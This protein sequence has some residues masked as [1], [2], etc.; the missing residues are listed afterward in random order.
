MISY[1][2]LL[3]CLLYMNPNIGLRYDM[4]TQSCLGFKSG[5][6]LQT[7]NRVCNI[8][9][10][11]DDEINVIKSFFNEIP[12]T[13]AVD[14]H[15]DATRTVLEKN[16]LKYKGSFP[17]MLLDLAIIKDHNDE[18]NFE[19]QH[20]NLH[21][22]TELKLWA[23]VFVRLFQINESELLKLL[24]C[25]IERIP[26]ALKLYLGY[27]QGAVASAC[28]VI[29]HQEIAAM[30]WVGTLPEYRNRGLA[31]ALSHKALNDAKDG[32]CKYAVLMSTAIAKK[33]YG[34]LGFEEYATYA[35]Y[36]SL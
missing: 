33:I 11:T 10:P 6:A 5:C 25:F 18:N 21:E 13:W 24:E 27:Y 31:F 28:M 30:H 26:N 16:N 36:G 22:T 17:A 34:H 29:I 23:S 4:I 15:D 12:F 9:V 32:G 35:M 8:E 20:I 2:F 1:F 14:I 19:I 3:Q 7:C